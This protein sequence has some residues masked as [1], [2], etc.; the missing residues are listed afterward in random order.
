[1]LTSW[2]TIQMQMRS[3]SIGKV[4]FSHFSRPVLRSHCQVCTLHAPSYRSSQE[5]D[6][7]WQQNGFILDVVAQKRSL[8]VREHCFILYIKY[9]LPDGR[10][11]TPQYQLHKPSWVKRCHSHSVGALNHPERWHLSSDVLN[12]EVSMHLGQLCV[13]ARERLWKSQAKTSWQL[14]P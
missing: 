10:K 14:S 2:K 1:M 4:L 7:E 11:Q 6:K 5:N 13:W 12:A 3:Y 8:E 9:I